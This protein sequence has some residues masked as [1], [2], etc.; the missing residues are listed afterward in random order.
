[1]PARSLEVPSQVE[2]PAPSEVVPAGTQAV[3]ESVLGATNVKTQQLAKVQK[4]KTKKVVQ[5]PLARDALA[6]VGVDP[7]AEMYWFAAIQ[8][9]TLPKSERQDLID[10]LNEEGL[11][12]PKHPTMDDLLLILSR[13]EILEAVVPSLSDEFDWKEPYGDLMNLA[14]LAM[15][16]GK[17]V[18]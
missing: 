1:V 12:D 9:P 11:A 10:D 5:D 4:P 18:Q 3:E 7:D 2:K 14:E 16:G 17:P 15:G 6:M 8:D 13:L